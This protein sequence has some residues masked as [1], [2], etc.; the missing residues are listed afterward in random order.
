MDHHEDAHWE[1]WGRR[2]GDLVRTLSRVLAPFVVVMFAVTAFTAVLGSTVAGAAPVARPAGAP[3]PTTIEQSSTPEPTAPTTAP[4]RVTVGSTVPEAEGSTDE[5]VPMS[6]IAGQ[7]VRPVF[8]DLTDDQARRLR[9]TFEACGADADRV[10]RWLVDATGNTGVA[11]VGQWFYDVPLRIL[12]VLAIAYVVNRIVRRSI[13]RYLRRLNRRSI[14]ATTDDPAK[15]AR[16][17]LRMATASSTLASAASVA[18]FVTAGLVLLGDLGVSL[19]P[20]LAGAGV[21]GIAVGFGAQHLVRD[22]VAGL[23]VLIEDQYGVGDVI[24]AGRATGVV[25][26]FSLRVTKIRDLEGTLWFVPNG[27]IDDVGN[28]TQVWSRSILDIEVAYGTDHDRAGEIIKAAADRVWRE[29]RPNTVIIEEPELWG[30]ERLGESGVAIRLAVKCAPADQWK[31]SRVLRGEIKRDLDAA[32]VEIPFPQQ[33]L[34]VRSLV[35]VGDGRDERS[36]G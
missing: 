25:E 21:V 5:A 11:Q 17:T 4:D 29:Q 20:L 2:R 14:D 10:C 22:V 30:V 23:F 26:D 1:T 32:D 16:S 6:R 36:D 35:G 24:D 3:P 13:E 34:W 7:D 18:I 9:N 12:F 15:P 31:V 33:T 28:K 8:D 27:T 19:G